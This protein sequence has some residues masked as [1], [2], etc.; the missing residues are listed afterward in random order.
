MRLR[1]TSEA[2]KSY[3]K[4]VRLTC[5]IKYV[6]FD[7]SIL[8]GHTKCEEQTNERTDNISLK[9]RQFI[10]AQSR[11]L[12]LFFLFIYQIVNYIMTNIVPH[13]YTEIAGH[14]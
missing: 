14:Q 5:H 8:A 1:F 7:V 12:H 9:K 3:L 10:F 4:E 13:V 6:Y 11:L 2:T